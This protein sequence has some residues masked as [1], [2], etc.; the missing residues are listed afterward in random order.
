MV[1]RHVSCSCIASHIV[2][3]LFVICQLR[4]ADRVRDGASYTF[5]AAA[6]SA[7]INAGRMTGALAASWS[8]LMG[9]MGDR[10]TVAD[11][12]SEHN[13]GC[14]YTYTYFVTV[15]EEFASAV[16]IRF[17]TIICLHVPRHLIKCAMIHGQKSEYLTPCNSIH[18]GIQNKTCTC[19][20]YCPGLGPR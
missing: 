19:G 2:P 7:S 8:S 17:H 5:N 18:T 20:V 6:A 3:L 9:A 16:G 14:G 4:C 1:S 15:T 10:F 12:Q 11:L 13:S